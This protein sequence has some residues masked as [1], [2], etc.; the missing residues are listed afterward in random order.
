MPINFFSKILN[1][2]FSIATCLSCVFLSL[3]AF[4]NTSNAHEHHNHA[5]DK[6]AGIK[7]TEVSYT[8]PSIKLVRQDDSKVDLLKELDDGRPVVLSFVYTSCTAICPVTSQVFSQVQEMLG[9]DR[10]K[11]RLMSISIDPE[12]DTPSRL[13][14][15]AKKYGAS[16]DWQFYTGSIDSSIAVQK[17]FKAYQGDKMNHIP[18]T[19]VRGAPGQSWV[20]LDG[21]A[22]PMDVIQELQG[23]KKVSHSH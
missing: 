12:Y 4:V 18:V 7:R 20:R 17:A 6:T 23:L 8:L 3:V 14:S 9:K 2:G 15:Y 5:V 22:S 19:F 13:A 16:L 21:F 11:V 10:G 1:G